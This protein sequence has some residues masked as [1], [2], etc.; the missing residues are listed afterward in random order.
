MNAEAIYQS[1]KAE[2]EDQRLLL[3][4]AFS[5]LTLKAQKTRP[6]YTLAFQFLQE[7]MPP[8]NPI[9]E[10]QKNVGIKAKKEVLSSSRPVLRAWVDAFQTFDWEKAIPAPHLA[11]KQIRELLALAEA[12]IHTKGQF[13]S[14]PLS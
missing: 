5:N 7:W 14:N 9:F 11:V 2:P 12:Q 3:S 13:N 1:P 6:E 10:P 8:V 4:Y